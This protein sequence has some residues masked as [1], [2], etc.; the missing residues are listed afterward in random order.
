M[1]RSLLS[2]HYDGT[3]TRWQQLVYL[4]TGL[5]FSCL[6]DFI[7]PSL[8]FLS[9][10]ALDHT[11]GA[12]PADISCN[13]Q[14]KATVLGDNLWES[15]F[16]WGVR[17]VVWRACQVNIKNPSTQVYRFKRPQLHQ[18]I[19]RLPLSIPDLRNNCEGWN[20]NPSIVSDWQFL[21]L[22]WK[23]DANFPQARIMDE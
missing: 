6:V 18:I 1:K 2:E 10:P 9:V 4:C 8:F 20:A 12:S 15:G 5:R 23:T 17:V 13:S 21:L 14:E 19:T 16:S 22:R 11:M 7:K 3:G